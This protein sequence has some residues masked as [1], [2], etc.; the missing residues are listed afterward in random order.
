V[1]QLAEV[2]RRHDAARHDLQR[3]VAPETRVPSIVFSALA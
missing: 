3:L 2:Q 1:G